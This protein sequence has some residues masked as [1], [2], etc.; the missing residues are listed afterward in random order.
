MSRKVVSILVMMVLMVSM[1]SMFA[2]AEY[3]EKA[4]QF[5]VPWSPGGGSDTLM[6]IV[7]KH[8][9]K[10]LGVPVPVINKPGVSGTVGLRELKNKTGNGYT[11][12]QVHEGL[13]AAYHVGITDINCDDFIPV[14]AMTSSPQFLAVRK[15]APYDNVEEFVEYAKNN[16]GDVSVGITLKGIPHIWAAIFE[17]ALDTE[18]KYV[19]YEGTGERVQAL[20]GGFIDIAMIDYAS[21]NQFVENGDFKFIAFASEERSEKMPDIPTLREKGYDMIWTVQ[22][23]VVLPK[24]TPEDI[25]KT[26]ETALKKTANDPEYVEAVEKTGSEVQFRGQEDYQAYLEKLDA[27]IASVAEDIK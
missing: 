11:I 14:A 4:V 15:D 18:F 26:L 21:G 8:A 6:R 25:V 5:I 23:G 24:G 19:S 13:L 12:G 16:P 2:A 1:L 9:E 3:P 20:A 22:R 27:D 17:K 7:A 10:Y